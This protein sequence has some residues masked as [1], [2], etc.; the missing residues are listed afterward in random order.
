MTQAILDVIG[1]VDSAAASII[2]ATGIDPMAVV[3]LVGLAWLI[4]WALG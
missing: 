3:S 1:W 4:L 2:D